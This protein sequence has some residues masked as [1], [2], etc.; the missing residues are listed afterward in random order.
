MI[1]TKTGR[2]ERLADGTANALQTRSIM[3]ATHRDV[4][5]PSPLP[6]GLRRASEE[7]S[8]LRRL[9]PPPPP[10][11]DTM[12]SLWREVTAGA[13]FEDPDPTYTPVPLAPRAESERVNLDALVETLSVAPPPLVVPP[14]ALPTKRRSASALPWVLA[15]A[16]LVVA[17]FLA[18]LLAAG[19]GTAEPASTPALDAAPMPPP[20][21]RVVTLEPVVFAATQPET[22]ATAPKRSSAPRA[23]SAATP[24]RSVPAPTSS[25]P[26]P[27]SVAPDGP[28]LAEMPGRADVRAALDSIKAEVEAC[29]QPADTG[30]LAHVRVT[31]GS[32]GRALHA[33]VDGVSGA[34]ASCIARAARSAQ[35]PPFTRA[36]FAVAAPFTL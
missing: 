17:A 26:A 9:S 14:V 10:R 34:T 3:R 30:R 8:G 7:Q 6:E 24:T 12:P 23:R 4:I 21:P 18:G 27:V 25:T 11:R 31:F 20:A 16:A 36:H 19:R 33:V 28:A 13:P 32:D 22:E 2:L 15:A 5:V 35:V 29:A 1:P